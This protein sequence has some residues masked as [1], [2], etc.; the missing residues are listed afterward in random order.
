MK[1]IYF[2][3]KIV[4]LTIL[5]NFFI[6]NQSFSYNKKIKK[7]NIIQLNSKILNKNKKSKHN[8]QS[9]FNNYKNYSVGD[10][11]LVIFNEKNI[12]KNKVI[13][14]LNK[15]SNNTIYAT[16]LIRENFFLKKKKK[17]NDFNIKK[18]IYINNKMIFKISTT[19]IKILKNKYLKVLGKKKIIINNSI[20]TIKFRGIIDAKKINLNNSIHSSKVSNFIIQYIHKNIKKNILFFYIKKII[21]FFF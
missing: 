1:S 11:I 4:L 21:H 2:F 9:W 17:T 10:T 6:Y 18:K 20:Q 16:P 13:K 12:F 5:I 14:Y 3:F 15:K 8:N 19:V 7:N